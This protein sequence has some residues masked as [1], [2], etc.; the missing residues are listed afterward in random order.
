MGIHRDLIFRGVADQP[1]VVGKGDIRWC[2]PIT[3][4]VGDDLNAIILPYTDATAST[5]G[6][7]KKK[8]GRV[9][10]THE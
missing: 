3:L 5:M 7:Q 4:V 8:G 10:Y 2:G 9:W 6:Q 1:L